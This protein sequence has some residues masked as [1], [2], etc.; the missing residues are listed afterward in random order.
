MDEKVVSS[1]VDIIKSSKDF[2]LSQVPEVAKQIILMGRIS[3]VIAVTVFI[4]SLA[5]VAF[6][7]DEF[8]QM[9]FGFGAA[10][11]GIISIFALYDFI[12]TFVAPKLYLLDYLARLISK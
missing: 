1:L 10:I 9:V 11:S 7:Q 8:W 5:L 4:A 3:D 2:V 12:E 6:F